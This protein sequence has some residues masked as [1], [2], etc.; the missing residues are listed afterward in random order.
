MDIFFTLV[1]LVLASLFVYAE[2]TTL[3]GWQG[4]WRLAAALPIVALIIISLIII[5][6]TLQDKTSHN[7]WPLE[8]VAWMGGGL[9]FLGLLGL[10]RK[11]GKK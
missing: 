4:G 1:L 2:I 9:V 10:V 5:V 11:L 7:L 3:R 6:S 8:I